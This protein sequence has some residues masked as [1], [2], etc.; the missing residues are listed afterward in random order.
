MP[1]INMKLK[2]AIRNND[3]Q[4]VQLD[5]FDFEGLQGKKS[6]AFQFSLEI[7]SGFAIKKATPEARHFAEALA[8][9]PDMM[10]ILRVGHYSFK[11]EKKLV[12]NIQKL[13]PVNAETHG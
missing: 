7:K 2:A 13:D 4:K 6:G 11:L 1:L 8:Q 5:H 3:V 12:L 9:S 10:D